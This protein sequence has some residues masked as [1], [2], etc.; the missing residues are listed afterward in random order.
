[1]NQE[2]LISTVAKRY[3]RALL[4]AGIRQ[5]NFS[6]ALEELQIFHNYLQTVPLLKA[7]FENPA[8]PHERKTKI[9]EDLNRRF[10]FQE[11]TVKLLNMLV[12]RDRLKL[13][14]Q[15]IASAKQQFLEKQGIIVVEVT[16]ARKLDRDEET[17]LAAKLESYTGK[18][19]QLENQIDPSLI[20][21][22][23]TR[24]G[25]TLYDG[26]VEAQLQ[27]LKARIQEEV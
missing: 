22:V 5:R 12:R 16:T 26:S 14:D 21:G 11:L 10:G 23:I 6:S 13:L 27:H 17:K 19:V 4:E 3:A 7:L 1:M 24:I 8:V 9:L 18:K 20:G 25:T 2:I 15:I